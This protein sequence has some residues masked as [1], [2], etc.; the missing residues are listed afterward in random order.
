M[1]IIG[2]LIKSSLGTFIISSIS[3]VISGL[4][5]S[6]LIYLINTGIETRMEKPFPLIY[7]FLGLWLLYGV[8]SVVAVY[9][10][11]KAAQLVILKMRVDIS[12]KIL[13]SSFSLLENKS[14]K[15]LTVLTSDINTISN[16]VNRL[17]N[18]LTGIATIIGCFIYMIYLSPIIFL[19]F[20]V[21]ILITF[22][23]NKLPLRS[24]KNRMRSARNIQSDVFGLF[25]GLVHGLKELTLSRKL[26]DSFIYEILFP[27]A[28]AQK[29]ENLL[30]RTRLALFSKSGE[31]V[32]LLGI[33]IILLLVNRIET[34]EYSVLAQ[35]LTIAL[36]TIGPLS[37]LANF[38]PVLGQIDVAMEKINEIGVTL[39]ENAKKESE[40]NELPVT[41]KK[42]PLVELK[43][44]VYE[45]YV[46]EEEKNFQLGPIDLKINEGEL[47]FLVGGN[48][49]GKSTMAKVICGLYRP[50]SGSIESKGTLITEEYM[51]SYREQFNAVFTDYYLFNHF[52]HLDENHVN[53]NV[54]AYIKLLE[55]ENKVRLK[56]MKLTTTSLSTGQRKRLALLLALLEDK[57]FYIFDEWAA[58]QDPYY[59][60]VY[61]KKILPQLK[62]N[63]K[64][65]L[66]ISHDDKYFDVAD[67][68]IVLR[69]GDLSQPSEKGE[70]IV[71]SVYNIENP[72]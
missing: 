43:D 39:E 69:D 9:S 8:M 15:I 35:F 42:S 50:V 41:N 18:S 51:D 28:E 23:L 62:A 52:Y 27:A 57:P 59:K 30:G 58:S 63:G 44:V 70:A 53:Q 67:R 38:L 68:V 5:L 46:Q 25:E 40:L 55:L 61:Y 10:I 64:T 66:A 29:N 21:V 4:S 12:K 24:Y 26:R 7:Q 14:E 3:A 32:V 54:K 17:P 56:D 36:F 13:K 71:H 11:T 31:M 72:N 33:G 22:L 16:S 60:D 6:G 2:L 47:I 49:S 19:M 20:S 45:Y 37:R 65:I 48:G 34:A 1:K